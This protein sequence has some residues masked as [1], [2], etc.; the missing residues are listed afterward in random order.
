M[1]YGVVAWLADERN[2]NGDGDGV[3]ENGVRVDLRRGFVVGGVS[4]GGAAAATIG[5]IS[6][7]LSRPGAGDGP[8]KELAGLTPLASPITGIFSGIPSLLHQDMLPEQYRPLFTSRDEV[9]DENK[10]ANDAMR[11]EMESWLDV[12]SPWF[13]PI[14]LERYL[15]T[16]ISFA[17]HPPKV[18]IYGCERD[19]FR[20]DSVV[21]AKWLEHLG[22]QV[23]AEMLKGEGHVAWIAPPWPACHSQK[24]KEVTFS[25][26]SWL[27]GRD[28]DVELSVV[29][30]LY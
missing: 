7:L 14:N 27:L 10:A 11:A 2:L 9:F 25:G 13:S 16:K 24:I 15:D 1:A 4:A 28:G 26:M 6:T 23:R 5:S 22:V 12:H 8:V 3:L 21:Y 19:Q 18:F 17:G 30:K 20:D 29:N